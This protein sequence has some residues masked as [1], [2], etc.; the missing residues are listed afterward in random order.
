MSE[1][2]TIVDAGGVG[3]QLYG[4]LDRDEAV[5]QF[6][7]CYERRAEEARGALAALEAGEEVVYHQRGVWAI[8]DR[9]EVPRGT[10]PATTTRSDI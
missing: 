9:R 3:I 10:A 5:S 6:R 1:R 7:R 4:H 2:M 8:R